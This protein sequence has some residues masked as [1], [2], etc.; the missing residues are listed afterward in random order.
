MSRE[1]LRTCAGVRAECIDVDFWPLFP[2]ASGASSLRW[3][4]KSEF[5]T[6]EKADLSGG[7]GILESVR[8]ND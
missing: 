1:G 6:M 8:G 5:F 4:D 2:S 7:E 3:V